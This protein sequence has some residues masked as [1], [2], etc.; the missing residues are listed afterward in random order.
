MNQRRALGRAEDREAA[1]RRR[2]LALSTI[3]TGCALRAPGQGKIDVLVP[4][5]MPAALRKPIVRAIETY[6]PDRGGGKAQ[7]WTPRRGRVS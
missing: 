2:A 5:N 6:K 7:T 1:S 4:A 3:L